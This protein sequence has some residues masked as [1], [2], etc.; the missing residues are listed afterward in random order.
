[1]MIAIRAAY[2]SKIPFPFHYDMIGRLASNPTGHNVLAISF[3]VGDILTRRIT[4]DGKMEMS[5][6]RKV[7]HRKTKSQSPSLIEAATFKD[8][9]LCHE[10]KP[11]PWSLP[12]FSF[13]LFYIICECRL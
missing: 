13:Y 1:M 6:P 10:K 5:L 8:S 11:S 2:E 4:R 9:K 7:K 3:E 12:L